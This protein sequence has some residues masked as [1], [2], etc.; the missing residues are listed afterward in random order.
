MIFIS[1][2][3][4]CN[5]VSMSGKPQST[6][7]CSK[8]FFDKLDNFLSGNEYNKVAFLGDYFDKGPHFEITINKIIELYEKYNKPINN[9][10][11]K[12]VYI[13]LGNR[14]LNKLRLKHEYTDFEKRNK[15]YGTNPINQGVLWDIWKSYYTEYF[16]ILKKENDSTKKDDI[17]LTILDKSMGAKPSN[18][19][20]SI[21]INYFNKITSNN[22]N[23]NKVNFNK[24]YKYGKIVEYDQTYKVLLSHAGGMDSFFFHNEKYYENIIKTL[25]PKMKYFESIEKARR[26]LMESP[27]N[28]E[29]YTGN[30]INVIIDI[31]N[32]PLMEYNRNNNNMGYYYILQAL[33]LK[34]DPG[35]HF[36]SFV[37]S[38]D[39]IG[40]KGPRINSNYQNNT[41]KYNNFLNTLKK[42]DIKIVSAGHKPHCA[43]IPLIYTREKQS[44]IIFIAN[45]V[46][47]G[48]RPNNIKDVSDVPLSYA[49]IQNNILTAVGVGMFNKTNSNIRSKNITLTNNIVPSLKNYNSMIQ[50]W[51]L[52]DVPLFGEGV[53]KYSDTKKLSFDARTGNPFSPSKII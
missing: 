31:L 23:L 35:K 43:P 14:D 26:L 42:M 6:I 34:P 24:L 2:L 41:N 44:E 16:N 12:R 3:E 53:V 45:D 51:E 4:G 49:E 30:N 52:K 11:N 19:D 5:T 22:S 27:K 8:P 46:S 9:P 10:T 18:I 1:D 38:C 28:D 7:V 15:E 37:E 40:C 20:K 47:N 50:R 13:I 17:L 48:Y 36:V 33:G 21:V 25:T 29:I 32:K 39:S